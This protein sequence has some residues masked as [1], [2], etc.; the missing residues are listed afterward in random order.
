MGELSEFEIGQTV[1]IQDGKTAIVQF[2]GNTDFAAGDWIGVVLNDATGK[3]DGSV[4]GQRYFTCEP[5]HGMF[6]RPAAASIFEQ[7]TPKPKEKAPPRVNGA[8]LKSRPPS[9][10]DVGL[11]R[12]SI[13]DANASRR[14]SINES[15]P[16]PGIKAVGANRL[17]VGRNSKLRHGGTKADF[18]SLLA[19][20]QPSSSAHVTPL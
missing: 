13:L 15:S 14:Q 19:S 3:N 9:M 8:A 5:G 1:E 16:T 20:L 18:A 11:R 7:P 6:V 12:Q 4:K 17:A 2:V 10:A